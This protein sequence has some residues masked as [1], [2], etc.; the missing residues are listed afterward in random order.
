LSPHGAASLD[1]IHVADGAASD[2]SKRRGETATQAECQRPSRGFFD[3]M[4]T[5]VSAGKTGAANVDG[6]LA[7]SSVT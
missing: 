7:E 6:V 5:A 1:A 2:E 3:M 4:R